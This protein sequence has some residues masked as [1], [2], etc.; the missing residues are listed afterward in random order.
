[1]LDPKLLQLVDV[2][3]MFD[4]L[5][6]WHDVSAQVPLVETP[7]ETPAPLRDL[8]RRFGVRAGPDLFSGQNTLV[9]P[10]RLGAHQLVIGDRRYWMIVQENQNC[11]FAWTPVGR[12]DDPTIAYTDTRDDRIGSTLTT[13]SIPLSRFLATH[14]LVEATLGSQRLWYVGHRPFR[15]DEF[16]LPLLPLALNLAMGFPPSLI[17]EFYVD[18]LEQALVMNMPESEFIYIATR[19]LD[20]GAVVVDPALYETLCADRTH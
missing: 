12:G 18:P 6:R 2:R 16:R 3:E 15:A 11:W 1:M 7:A 13:T 20:I 5:A 9:D 14:V 10:L 4:F 19:G 8:Y 17:Y